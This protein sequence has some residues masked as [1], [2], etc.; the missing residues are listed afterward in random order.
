VAGRRAD[1]DE[2]LQQ[3]GELLAGCGIADWRAYGWFGFELSYLL[4]GRPELAGDATLAHLIVP[5]AEAR[6]TP[7]NAELRALRIAA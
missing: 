4:H 7:N 3:V 6:L 5:A 1:G 2:P